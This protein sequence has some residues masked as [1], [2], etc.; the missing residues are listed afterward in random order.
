MLQEIVKKSRTAL[1]PILALGMLNSPVRAQDNSLDRYFS[2]NAHYSIPTE[3]I[4]KVYPSGMQYGA[5]F[6][7]RNG[8]LTLEGEFSRFQSTSESSDHGSTYIFGSSQEK[9]SKDIIV[10]SLGLNLLVN[11]SNIGLGGGVVAENV[12]F[13]ENYY[14]AER[15]LFG[16]VYSIERKLKTLPFVGEQAI[17]EAR[18]F[19]GKNFNLTLRA[20]AKQTKPFDVRK[21]DT[22]DIEKNGSFTVGVRYNFVTQ[23]TRNPQKNRR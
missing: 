17:L 4:G 14:A 8:P 12:Q 9:Y 11:A 5:S 1:L 10:N 7:Q 13:D 2:I 21:K 18:M 3:D 20:T 22:L 19:E 6:S 16:S 23:S 15:G